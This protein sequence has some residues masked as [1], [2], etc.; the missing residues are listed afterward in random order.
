MQQIT[1][2]T[3]N[4][5]KMAAARAVCEPLDIN[6]KQAILDIP[7]IQAEDAEIIARDKASKAYSALGE[8]VVISDDTWLI[9]GLNGFPGAYMKSMNHWLTSED[10]LRLTLPLTDR[11]IILRQIIV[12]QDKSQQK[13][14]SVDTVGQ[15]LTEIRGQS[16]YP[17]TTITS[18][19]EDGQS[20][21]EV[22]A[23][24][25]SAIAHRP[26]SWHQLVAWLSSKD[27]QPDPSE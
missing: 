2:V 22:A 9:P 14:F 17:H 1:F 25:T 24:S 8:P 13:V 16:P 18:F 21:A 6:V 23:T 15:L 10:F 11:R 27:G 5:L 4:Q 20:A 12:Y 3:G 19:A 26:T 7:E